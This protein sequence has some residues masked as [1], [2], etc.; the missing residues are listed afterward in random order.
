MFDRPRHGADLLAPSSSGLSVGVGR[1]RDRNP[2]TAHCVG[3][4]EI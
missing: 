4:E 1:C 2:E 3:L